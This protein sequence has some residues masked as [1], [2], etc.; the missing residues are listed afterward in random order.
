ME[1][2]AVILAHLIFHCNV[3]GT[4][5]FVII[6]NSVAL[7][8]IR[9]QYKLMFDRALITFLISILSRFVNIEL[10]HSLIP[11]ESER[12]SGTCKLR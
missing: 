3:F 6:D 12:V 1:S 7:N 8:K 5:K 9:L 11:S 2:I 10:V 4:L